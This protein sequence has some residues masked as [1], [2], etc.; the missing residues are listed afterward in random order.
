MSQAL[1]EIQV[2]TEKKKVYYRVNRQGLEE[3][4]QGI[5]QLELTR[6]ER[7]EQVQEELRKQSRNAHAGEQFQTWTM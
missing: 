2:T 4:S 1:I 6:E 3:V 5:L 7:E